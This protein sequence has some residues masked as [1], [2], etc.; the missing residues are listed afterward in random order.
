MKILVCGSRGF[1]GQNIIK[2]LSVDNVYDVYQFNR[3]NL[4]LSNISKLENVMSKL[5][6]D[7][8]VN[9]AAH[10]GSVH[11]VNKFAADVLMDNTQF[12]INIYKSLL[13]TKNFNT[14]VIN[15]ISNCCYP[16]NPGINYEGCWSNGDLHESIEGYGAYKRHL[17]HLSRCM[18]RQYDI[19]TINCMFPGIFGPGDSVDPNKA[20]A[21]NGM[22]SRAIQMLPNETKFLVS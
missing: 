13:L 20:H 18:F 6:P 12:S 9:C 4:D 3:E 1:L 17:I 10:V 22:I 14:L 11:Y 2:K 16:E 19:R 21:L 7:V 15:P 5:C 8:I